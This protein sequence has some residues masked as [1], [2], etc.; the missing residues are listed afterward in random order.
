MNYL[1]VCFCASFIIS[2]TETWRVTRT[3]LRCDKYFCVWIVFFKYILLAVLQ[4]C[5]FSVLPHKRSLSVINPRIVTVSPASAN[6]GAHHPTIPTVPEVL[7]C[8]FCHGQLSAQPVHL[9]RHVGHLC[10]QSGFVVSHFHPSFFF[11][12]IK[13]ISGNHLVLMI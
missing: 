5:S 12:N 6:I 10:Q 1:T 9:F 4:S 13:I 3:T 8:L 7:I 2:K 11:P